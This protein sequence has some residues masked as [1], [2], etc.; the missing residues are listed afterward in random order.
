VAE[1][2]KRGERLVQIGQTALRDPNG[3]F[4]PAVPMY[5][6]V[7]AEAVDENDLSEG[8]Q[9]L[10]ADISGLF[11][12]KFKQYVDGIKALNREG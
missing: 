7:P 9:Q 1:G 4:L 6:K 8:E 2:L 10:V 3:G 11:A 5:I 12:E